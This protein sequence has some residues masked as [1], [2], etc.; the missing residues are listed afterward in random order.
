[1]RGAA[2]L[3]GLGLLLAA[4]PRADLAGRRVL[5]LS[6]AADPLVPAA[7][8]QRLARLL[9]EAG[10]AVEHRVLPTGHGLTQADVAAARAWIAG[11]PA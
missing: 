7:K 2:L 5:V 1:M 8:A 3:L 11:R 4:P 6:G 9:A 10:A